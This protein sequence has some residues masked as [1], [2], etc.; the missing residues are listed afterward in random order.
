MSLQK[1]FASNGFIGEFCAKRCIMA[2]GFVTVGNRFPD[3]AKRAVVSIEPGSEFKEITNN[4]LQGRW[5]VFFWWPND[6]TAICPTELAA[7]NRSFDLFAQR[8]AR[9]FG[10]S[11]DSEYVHLAWRKSH[12]DLQDLR[13]PMIA[14]TS[15]FLA[16]ALGILT[17]DD[18]VALRTT[19]IIDPEG[20]IR[21]MC[22]ND[23]SVGRNIDEVLRVLDALLTDEPC[24]CNWE[25]G[26]DTLTTTVPQ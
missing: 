7:F 23:L 5:A 11:T 12:K 16:D 14:D 1:T 13:F 9:L 25:K 21:W 10:A 3:F 8:E 24:P 6:F 26:Q 20:T 17:G 19:Y 2:E 4:N 15:K 22:V 18:R